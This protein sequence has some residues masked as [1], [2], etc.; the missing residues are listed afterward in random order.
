MVLAAPFKSIYGNDST[1][2]WRGC[3]HTL[4]GCLMCVCCVCVLHVYPCEDLKSSVVWISAGRAQ[5]MMCM[6]ERLVYLFISWVC[7]SGVGL[8]RDSAAHLAREHRGRPVTA[9]ESQISYSRSTLAVW[10]RA[11][12]KELECPSL[13]LPVRLSVCLFGQLCGGGPVRSGCLSLSIWT[14]S[15]PTAAAAQET[16]T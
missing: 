5:L 1:A 3:T 13:S 9:N 15:P 16:V 7:I 4:L 12:E 6:S 2:L 14:D 11:K 10:E 8:R